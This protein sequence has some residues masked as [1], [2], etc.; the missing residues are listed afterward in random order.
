M[1]IIN[2]T[3]L[4]LEFTAL[5]NFLL[6]KIKIEVAVCIKLSTNEKILRIRYDK[7]RRIHISR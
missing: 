7:K 1:K 2:I 3:I 4:T 6:E 5:H